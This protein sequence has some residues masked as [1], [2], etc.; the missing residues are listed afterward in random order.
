[1]LLRRFIQFTGGRQ[2][3][4]LLKGPQG[5]ARL[6]SHH[7]IQRTRQKSPAAPEQ[8]APPATSA[9]GTRINLPGGRHRHI[10]PLPWGAPPAPHWLSQEAAAKAAL[11]SRGTAAFVCRMAVAIFVLTI[12]CTIGPVATPFDFSPGFAPLFVSRQKIQNTSASTASA[13]NHDKHPLDLPV[14]G[15]WYLVRRF[16]FWVSSRVRRVMPARPASQLKKR[17]QF[18]DKTLGVL[19]LLRA[20]D[21]RLGFGRQNAFVLH[22]TPRQQV[23]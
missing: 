1:M 17:P 11:F 7:P 3:F 18:V 12:R 15:N 6:R 4:V 10:C 23:A 20:D 14:P 22:L 8:P 19:G 2:V 16:T 13:T 21:A 5:R 9:P